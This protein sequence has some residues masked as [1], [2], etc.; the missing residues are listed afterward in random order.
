VCAFNK[1]LIQGF[2]NTIML[3]GVVSCEMVFRPLF[4]QEVSKL[5]AK[6]LASAVRMESFN[7]CA[8]LS[9]CPCCICLVSS[10]SLVLGLQQ[11]QMRVLSVFIHK[12]Y[13]VFATTDGLHR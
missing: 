4:P 3:G 1:L 13:I 12:R 11:I 10:K 5:V 6:E 2:G 9:F 7:M 8:M